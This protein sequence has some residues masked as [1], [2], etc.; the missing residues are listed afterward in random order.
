MAERNAARRQRT[1]KALL[2][3]AG[4]VFVRRGYHPVRISEIVAQAGVGQ[5]TFYRYFNSKREVFECLLDELVDS[6][7]AG[8]ADMSASLP[9]SASEYHRASWQAFST[10][11][12]LIEQQRDLV[13]L[14]L[15]EGPAI[16]RDFEDKIDRVLQRFSALARF[17]LEHAIE[18][19]FARSC[20]PDIVS[21]AL[22]GAALRLFQV[23]WTGRLAELPL[24]A[25]VR[26]GIDFAFQG[27]GPGGPEEG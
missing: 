21:E 7:L 1:R 15:R 10:A 8:F 17:F 4:A 19:G 20:D 6:L 22:I 14:F 27:I 18:Q 25:I 5:G 16:D 12:A 11:A 24:A 9:A 23:R 26:E 2:D 13:R 3:A